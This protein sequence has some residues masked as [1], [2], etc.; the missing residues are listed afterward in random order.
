MKAQETE[1]KDAG[2]YAWFA[3][4]DAKM[5]SAVNATNFTDKQKIRAERV[6][7]AL[8]LVYSCK[9]V[10]IDYT[11]RHIRVKVH[12]P[13][14]KDRKNLRELETSWEQDGIVKV[15]TNQGIIYRVK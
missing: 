5:R 3:A 6:K 9:G 4:R 2:M 15:L 14:I 1:H 12:N 13:I 10:T 11:K 7:L 8:E